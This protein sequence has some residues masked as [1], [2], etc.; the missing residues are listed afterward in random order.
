MDSRL[1][2]QLKTIFETCQPRED[3]LKGSVTD[4]DFAADVAQV[5]KG[6]GSLDYC[7]PTRF[8]ANTYPT[9]GLTN[10]LGNVCRRL[11][12][13]GS[14]A[15]SIFRLDTA[16]GG[17]KSHSLIALC[18]AARHGTDVT[19]IGSFVNPS[20]L[21]RG[22]VRLAAF[23]GEN[24]DPSNGRDMGHGHKAY[25]P[26]GEIAYSLAGISGLN[27]VRTS[28]EKHIAPGAD[29]IRKL[30]GGEPTLIL[31]DELSV[32]LR[33][34]SKKEKGATEQLTAFLTAL[35]KAVDS[36][37]NAAV[38]FTLAVDKEGK[39]GGAY[40]TENTYIAESVADELEKVS[41]RKAT[42]L[43][44]TEDDETIHVL[45]RRLFENVDEEAARVAAQ[46]YADLWKGHSDSLP[47]SVTGINSK[48]LLETSYPLHP[49]VLITLTE[50]TATL[51][52][53]Q[54]VRGMLRILARTVGRLWDIKPKD[55][56]AIHLHHIDLDYLP[57]QQEFIT[58]LA[59]KQFVPAISYDISIGKTNG[60]STAEAIDVKH[61]TGQPPY[62]AY[63]A[64]TIF[65]HT[66]AFNERL[67]GVSHERLRQSMLGPTIGISY[68][69]K[70]RKQFVKES[71][72]LDDRPNS[73]L[74]FVA[75]ANLNSLI[76]K[77]EENSV[78]PEEVRAELKDRIK[79]LFSG[80]NLNL[81]AF[82]GGPW[83]VPDKPIDNRP[84]LVVVGYEAVVIG[85]TVKSVPELIE[86]IFTRKGN[87][88]TEVRL[89]RNNLVFVVA[90]EREVELMRRSAIRRLALIEMKKPE[91]IKLLPDH[92]KDKVN[93][94]ERQS[95]LELSLS[96]QNCYQHVFFPSKAGIKPS[97]AELAHTVVDIPEAANQLGD[98]HS[99]VVQHLRKQNELRLPHD[100]PDSPAYVRDRTP[101]KKGS[102]STAKLREEFRCDPNLTILVGDEIF[103]KGLKLGIND[104]EYVYTKGDLIYGKGDPDTDISIDS[105]STIYT[106]RE[107]K[108]KSVWPRQQPDDDDP[109]KSKST[110]TKEVPADLNGSG[111]VQEALV[112]LW[113]KARANKV[114]TIESI[115]IHV[116]SA[117]HSTAMLRAVRVIRNSTKSV[118]LNG[119]YENSQRG[120]LTLDFNGSYEE[121][122][123]V[124]EFLSQQF[125][126]ATDK[127]LTAKIKVTFDDG[128]EVDSD[129]PNYITE[130]LVKVA[131]TV[132]IEVFALP[133]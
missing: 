41:A 82:P 101:L 63:V 42:L 99:Q 62:T 13:V 52:N 104:G 50:K 76:R 12:G 29:T 2:T 48:E 26:W 38:V 68:I 40:G 59:Q 5:I 66:I 81:V 122:Q 56:V 1:G 16:Y 77:T 6:E 102:I 74:R 75:E 128:L 20:L 10:L 98:G 23:D 49:E 15:A 90:D 44:P 55:A 69:D 132:F 14:E 79:R 34:V 24:S 95:E 72:Y 123:L 86:Q 58:R 125:K 120:S 47:E 100:E 4:A 133:K 51:S 110:G 127:Q 64:R 8:F 78:N 25:T 3:I 31:L 87:E 118:V 92:Q 7:D 83:D 105:E 97:I 126:G 111:V 30:F 35:F 119:G 28:D 27:L 108:E 103:I 36:T 107:A 112:E 57:I 61:Y 93:E 70:A 21:P 84:N 19:N 96:V 45:R 22:S 117:E 46:A 94:L 88:A 71:A 39:A 18:H 113:D 114:T 60:H 53:F 116:D 121:A 33:K 9:R 65:M 54:R 67:K 11:S 89:Q 91:R 106:M 129:A 124:Q 131:S 115:D 43:N 85:S 80:K 17:G 37:P 130:R 73:P 32:Y 109:L